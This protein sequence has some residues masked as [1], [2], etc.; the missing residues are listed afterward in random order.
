MPTGT[1]AKLLINN[2]AFVKAANN[3]QG[4]FLVN[5]GMPTEQW[6]NTGFIKAIYSNMGL[7][8]N[9]S[10]MLLRGSVVSY[11]KLNVT[12]EM[13]AAGIAAGHTGHVALSNLG[14]NREITWKTPG[15]KA[16]DHVMDTLSEV[17]D[18]QINGS[19]VHFDNSWAG[20]PTPTVAATPKPAAVNMPPA[21]VEA[22]D[23]NLP[24]AE[25]IKSPEQLAAEAEEAAAAIANAATQNA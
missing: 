10:F 8:T 25:A 21:P 22:D 15:E 11:Y 18:T 4:S 19:G 7:S 9:T 20:T 24:P 16:F 17:L 12:P 1:K 3:G 6:L 23:D 5:Q 14:N 2:I 13:I